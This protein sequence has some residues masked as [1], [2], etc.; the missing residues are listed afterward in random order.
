MGRFIQKYILEIVPYRIAFTV[1]FIM[2]HSIR[3][4]LLM[5]F[6]TSCATNTSVSDKVEKAI[7]AHGGYSAFQEI[8]HLRYLKRTYS[9]NKEG[10]V[11]D[12]LI[13][14]LYHETV[15]HTQLRYQ[16]SDTVLVAEDRGEMLALTVNELPLNDAITLKSQRKLIEAA[17]YIFFQPFKLRDP[18]AVL[19]PLGRKQLNL[20]GVLKEVEVIAV[21]YSDSDDKWYFFFDPK[22]DQVVANAVDHNGKMSLIT[23]DSMQWHQGLL[24]HKARTSYLSNEDFELIRPQASYEYEMIQ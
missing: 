7:E 19:N 12:T 14:Y 21:N 1:A 22:T 20:S 9:L 17:N 24:V 4:V 16:R 6:I 11:T 15:N 10:V 23:N 5:V 3:F 2:I 8:E 18:N 13:Q